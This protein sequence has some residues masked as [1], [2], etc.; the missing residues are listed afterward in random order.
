VTWRT[1]ETGI[2]FLIDPYG[3]EDPDA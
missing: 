1:L 3:D 2:E